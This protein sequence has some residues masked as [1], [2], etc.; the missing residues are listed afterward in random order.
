MV[1]KLSY[2]ANS[3][4]LGTGTSKVV[5][6]A[7]SGNLIVK[8]SDANTS[9]IEPGSGIVGG[10]AVVTYAN[11]AA[12]PFSPISSAGSLAYTTSTSSLYMSNGSGWYKVTLINTAP[13]ITLSSTTAS[14]TPTNLTLDFTY[15]VT[16]P[17]GTPTTVSIANSG[18]ATTGNVAVTHTTSNNHVRLVFDGT[19]EYEGDATVTLTVTDGVNTGTGTITITTAYYDGS[20]S[21]YHSLLLKAKSD[22]A[23]TTAQKS[24]TFDGTG[25][26]LT[27]SNVDTAGTGQF[28]AE[29]FF[30]ASTLPSVGCIMAQ[31]ATTPSTNNYAQWIV[32]VQSNGNLA[33]YNGVSGQRVVE[34]GAG[35]VVANRWYHV[36]IT[37]NISNVATM[38]LDGVSVG[39]RSHTSNWNYAPFTIG[40]NGDG[41]EAFNGFISNVRWIVGTALYTSNFIVPTSPLTAVTNT[42]FLVAQGN[43]TDNSG[44]NE[45]VS[46]S[47]NVAVSN[48]SPF[49]SGDNSTFDDASDSNHVITGN[50]DVH[51][52]S[53]SPFR[54]P[55]YAVDFAGEWI[56]IKDA[57]FTFGTG[58]YTVEGWIFPHG[59]GNC[60][61]IDLRGSGM[62]QG[63][64][65]TLKSG[66]K[67]WPYYGGSQ[68][69]TGTQAINPNVW[70]HIALVR[71]SGTL[72][73]FINGRQDFSVSDTQDRSGTSQRD[74]AI[75][76]NYGGASKF[77]GLLYDWRVTT[78]AVYTSDFSPPSEPLTAI[79][80][81]V[82]HVLRGSRIA[83][84]SSN[85]Y[86]LEG[87]GNDS[88]RQQIAFTPYDRSSVYSTS[89][90]GG[91]VYHSNGDS[92]YLE[93]PA[94][95]DHQIYGGDYT[96][97]AWLYPTAFN[98]TYNYFLSK[99]GNGTR[100]WAFSISASNIIVYWSTNGSGT[101]DATV[102]KTTDNDL[103]QWTHVAFTKSGNT[104]TIYK[105]GISLG[106]GTFTSIYSGNG[107]TTVGRLW[108]YTGISHQYRGYISNLRIV[109]GSV[110]YSSNFTPPT[111]PVTAI[112]NTKLLLNFA[113]SKVFDAS[114][115]IKSLTL[116]GARASSAQQHFSENTI[117]FDGTNDY[118]A[119]KEGLEVLDLS[120]SKEEDFTIECWIYKTST[121]KDCWISHRDSSTTE[122]SINLDASTS[123]Y[124][125]GRI[126][127]EYDSGQYVVDVGIARNQWQHIAFQRTSEANSIHWYTDGVLKDTRTE[128]ASLV[129]Y[130]ADFQIGRFDSNQF[131]YN[132]Y[133]HD[134][135][136]SRGIARYPYYS[137]PVTLTTTNSGMTKPD[138][139]TVTVSASDVLLLTCHAGTEGSQT[140]TDGSTNNITI[141]ANG[142]AAVSNFGPGPGM[143]SVYFDGTGDYLQCT[144]PETLGTGDWTIEYW[145]YH[146]N[147]DDNDI[148]CAFGT[149]APAFYYRSAS[150]AF[151]YYSGGHNVN[152]TPIAHKWYHM[153]YSHDASDNKMR[154]FVNGAFIEEPTYNGNITS[155]TFRIGDDSTSAWMDGY[156]SNLRIVKGQ[157]LYTKDF[158][159]ST[160][161]FQ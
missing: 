131:Y 139:T 112:T 19:T 73:A 129:A 159:P 105:N 153:V 12:L 5:L 79:S 154:V 122:L 121:S 7:D 123:G 75:G 70:S 110:V 2:T 117:A 50:G 95:S 151:A 31:R 30:Y 11:P 47:G 20:N 157:V 156:I 63:V 66:N 150:N 53:Y 46:T 130:S 1:Q 24:L 52:G 137:K 40:A 78:N 147:I 134:F 56:K 93:I 3:I 6:G 100:E 144:L 14:P 42:K 126:N 15:T 34:T 146:N 160:S 124:S 116:S 80:G 99:G 92:D 119:V 88:Q 140:I 4:T 8:D 67:I 55:G 87:Q 62:D 125:A 103:Y 54:E 148:H 113:D 51:Q 82:L 143:K 49:Q 57:T 104:I 17:E 102:T 108:Q 13:S 141:T 90:H 97:E 111:S 106:T 60:D 16:E 64:A 133:M 145:V 27:S 96:V 45:T 33:W 72:K 35:G 101:G 161:A 23:L 83:D 152:I 65:L 68:F 18:I 94:S 120:S 25:D 118:I 114:Q 41:T 85:A 59:T 155:T 44:Q 58:D 48:S 136:F 149:Y 81:T 74:M 109:K 29:A 39:T 61:V 128:P 10:A 142:N 22:V 77:D 107:V 91:S 138:G 32:Y 9:I 37:R 132:G 36:A 158:T 89:N 98:T 43:T 86:A 26:Y 38:W 71:T 28:T 21:R 76:A 84:Y 69:T 115:S 127:V 135:R